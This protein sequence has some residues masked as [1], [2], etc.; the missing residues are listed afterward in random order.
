MLIIHARWLAASIRSEG[1]RQESQSSE[2]EAE[3]AIHLCRN[4]C[5]SFSFSDDSWLLIYFFNLQ[6]RRRKVM[7]ALI[8]FPFCSALQRKEKKVISLFPEFIL[9]T[10]P[11][12]IKSSLFFFFSP[13]FLQTSLV[14][15]SVGLGSSGDLRVAAAALHGI[16]SHG[17]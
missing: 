4:F 8:I 2:E 3:L 5:L 12:F 11:H 15:V 16:I 6:Q 13:F 7:L 17:R 9:P 1:W 14:R 10:R